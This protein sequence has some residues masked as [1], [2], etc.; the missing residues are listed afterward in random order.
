MDYRQF[1][2]AVA[3]FTGTR[4]NISSV[5]V[6]F[7]LQV[8]ELHHGDCTGADAEAHLLCRAACIKL[9]IHPPTDSRY[10]A[11]C[12]PG[13]MD[14]IRD[15]KPY[16]ARNMDIVTESSFL[17]AVP[18]GPRPVDTRGSG[19]WTTVGYAEQMGMGT[20][21]LHPYGLIEVDGNP[22]VR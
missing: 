2:F 6:L 3:G 22:L 21:I 14:E 20:I 11:F 1:A 9:V 12:R 7:D 5:E 17:I 18:D 4:K 8:P 16:L 10:R 19:T 15:P 13:L